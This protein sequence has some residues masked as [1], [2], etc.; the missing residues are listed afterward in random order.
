[1]ALLVSA[2][3]QELL[4]TIIDELHD[5]PDALKSCSLVSWQFLPQSQKNLFEN[6]QLEFPWQLLGNHDHRHPAHR[7]RE[8]LTP[9]LKRYIHHFRITSYIE[10]IRVPELRCYTQNTDTALILLLE[11]L[12]QLQSF[13][14]SVNSDNSDAC[15]KLSFGLVS[16][17]ITMFRLTQVVE[18]NMHFLEEFPVRRL[19]LH[20]LSIKKLNLNESRRF[21]NLDSDK[22]DVF[23]E[24]ASIH[25]A[26]AVL[27]CKTSSTS[28]HLDV[29]EVDSYSWTYFKA[30]LEATKLPHAQLTMSSVHEVVLIGCNPSALDFA[31]EVADDVERLTW[32]Y[33][34][35]IGPLG[36][37]RPVTA[38]FTLPPS[39][40]SLRLAF[41]HLNREN[42]LHLDWFGQALWRNAQNNHLEDIVLLLK[43]EDFPDDHDATKAWNKA[44]HQLSMIDSILGGYEYPHL[45]RVAIFLEYLSFYDE[46]MDDSIPISAINVVMEQLKERLPLLHRNGVLSVQWL[47]TEKEQKGLGV[48]LMALQRG[49]GSG[50]HVGMDGEFKIGHKYTE[51]NVC[52]KSENG[53]VSIQL[54]GWPQDLYDAILE[55]V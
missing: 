44:S 2:L 6:I 33:D 13:T 47:L 39:L 29:I 40:R 8:I 21:S 23:H 20:C 10:N 7:L 3:S 48:A 24:E 53:T 16:A 50:V 45:R 37:F 35:C 18:V 43:I 25:S 11:E 15:R 52:R 54:D 17:L 4:D 55:D 32:D 12:Q 28:G 46:D 27:G 31:L 49:I 42:P 26:A 36:P 34:H 41:S 22:C 1:M 38:F 5:D 19:A 14:L 9:R 51:K 30:L